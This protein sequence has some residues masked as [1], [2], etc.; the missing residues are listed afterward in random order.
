MDS[1]CYF[2]PH[3]PI[4]QQYFDLSSGFGKQILTIWK[5][6]QNSL[7][8]G[9]L[10]SD[11]YK[12]CIDGL[13]LDTDSVNFSEEIKKFTDADFLTIAA[14]ENKIRVELLDKLC[15]AFGGKLKSQLDYTT[16]YRLYSP[17]FMINFDT[18]VVSNG[19]IDKSHI[20]LSFMEQNTG[21]LIIW[22]CSSS[23][24]IV[25]IGV[26]F[27]WYKRRQT[28]KNESGKARLEA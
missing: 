11:S 22:I 7:L 1:E 13:D 5:C 21:L 15:K 28:D 3:L 18:N 6:G 26:V 14:F 16:E 19:S 2:D 23:V 4:N 27:L 20:A 8:D 24:V 12:A 17:S 10:V 25:L 9:S